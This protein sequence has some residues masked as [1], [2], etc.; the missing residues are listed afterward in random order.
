M[1]RNTATGE[2]H[3][4]VEWGALR[5]SDLINRPTQDGTYNG[6]V[7][8]YYIWEVYQGAFGTEAG[9]SFKTESK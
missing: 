7:S 4:R 5:D 1:L 6:Q 9:W 2:V 8:G 3:T